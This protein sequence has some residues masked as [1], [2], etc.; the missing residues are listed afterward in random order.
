MQD[1]VADAGIRLVVAD[2]KDPENVGFVQ[3]R[4]AFYVRLV[5]V[6]SNDLCMLRLQHAVRFLFSSCP[7]LYLCALSAV[8]KCVIPFRCALLLRLPPTP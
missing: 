7:L 1:L 4:V 6:R 8:R 2:A 5:V 3:W